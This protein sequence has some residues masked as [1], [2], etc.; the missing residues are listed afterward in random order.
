M[1]GEPSWISVAAGSVLC[2]LAA[3]LLL[4]LIVHWAQMHN[5]SEMESRYF[6]AGMP[7]ALR[8]VR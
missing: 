3:V 8:L 4:V 1:D 5:G 7:L 6:S 2:A